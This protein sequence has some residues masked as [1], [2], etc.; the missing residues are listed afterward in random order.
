MQKKRILVV[1]DIHGRI[2]WKAPVM[3]YLDT[4]DRV[5]FLGDFLDPYKDENQ[6]ADDLFQNLMEIINLKKNNMEKV[7]LLKGNHDQHY[8]SV[9]FKEVAGGTRMDTRNW[10]KYHQAFNE[11]KDLFRLVHVETLKALPIVFSHAGL[12]SYWLKKVNEE[13]WHLPDHQVSVADPEIIRMINQLDDDGKGQDLLAVVGRRRSRWFGEKT[14]SVLWADIEEHALLRPPQEYGLDKVFQ[15]FGH[16]QLIE[17]YDKL[18]L[19]NLAMIDSRQ[20]FIMD[21]SIKE[22]ILSAKKYK[23]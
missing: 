18:E 2:F 13:V 12:T 21:E 9:R 3:K 4:V 15:V 20:C 1:P 23:E 14:G 11:H 8:A 16:T 6:I 22:K 7:V 10:D 17:N 19:D 5:V